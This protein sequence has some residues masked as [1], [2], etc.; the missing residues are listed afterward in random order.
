MSEDI[1]RINS[2]NHLHE[3]LGL[4]KPKHPLIS[5]IDVS[6]LRITEEMINIKLV[7]NLYYIALKNS[8]CG[9]QYGRN[10]YDFEEG[11]LAFSAPNQVIMAKST[12]EFDQDEGWMLFFHPDLIR[13]SP[14]GENIEN[15]NFFSYDIH[16][17]LHLSDAEKRILKSCVDIIIEEYNQR[18]D[19]HSQKVIVSTLELLLNYC[20]R[21]YERQFN[22][23]EAQNKDIVS[24]VE[25]ILKDYYD[26]GELAELGPPSLN[27]LADKVN[28]SHN[29]LSD[30]LKK[31]TGRSAKEHINDFIVN[32]AK[33]LLLSTE[34]SVSEIA[35]EL[36]FNYPHYFS[37][38]FKNKTGLT[39]QKYRELQ[40]N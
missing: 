14:L 36:G 28:L 16:E 27:Y 1:I 12:H 23:R 20:S 30:L 3:L 7:A 13:T 17:A 2:I 31:E 29:Y 4:E 26:S 9:M 32:K 11:L 39:P 10:Y 25:R 35:Y 40:M 6:K 8:D 33:N 37:R 22:T 24:Q 38:L 15:Y 5:I 21:F 18:I 34:G 19:N